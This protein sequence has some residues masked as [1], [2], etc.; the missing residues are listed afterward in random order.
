MN[1]H[2]PHRE[3]GK[4]E[5][6]VDERRCAHVKDDGTRCKGWKVKGADLC[7]GH[8]NGFG[9]GGA[10]PREAASRSAE[11]RKASADAR[12]EARERA[13]GTLQDRTA[14]F[15]ARDDVQRALERRWMDILDNGS[16]SDAIRLHAQLSD[17][18]FGRPTERVEVEDVTLPS[19]IAD[20]DAMTPEQR[21]AA[22][23]EMTKRLEQRRTGTDD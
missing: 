15:L 16:D 18:V 12:S 1:Q 6:A 19:S 5:E 2:E 17:R 9:R 3:E 23:R 4:T 8:L 22:L 11:V 14:A 21:R 20:I 10:D 7:A 13:A